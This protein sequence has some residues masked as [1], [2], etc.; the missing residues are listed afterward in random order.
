MYQLFCIYDSA[1]IFLNTDLFQYSIVTVSRTF[2]FFTCMYDEFRYIRK[3]VGLSLLILNVF[4]YEFYSDFVYIIAMIWDLVEIT[5][6]LSSLLCQFCQ[7]EY[8]QVN[9]S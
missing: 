9:N 5:P 7:P 1:G 8:L 4:K 2:I 3:T 6:I